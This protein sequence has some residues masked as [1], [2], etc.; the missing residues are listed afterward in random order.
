MRREK[1]SE[2][3]SRETV[4]QE[5]AGQGRQRRLRKEVLQDARREV[6]TGGLEKMSTEV[7]SGSR[8]KRLREEVGEGVG[9]SRGRR[10]E[11]TGGLMQLR[12][13]EALE[14]KVA[15]GGREKRS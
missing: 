5:V 9:A 10:P 13:R 11:K 1:R 15:R 12:E 7:V 6:V 2:K 14:K 8:Q 3:K 4:P